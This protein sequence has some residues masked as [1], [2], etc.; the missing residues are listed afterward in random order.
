MVVI[1]GDVRGV[2]LGNKQG[3]WEDPIDFISSGKVPT[4]VLGLK[5][6]PID[7]WVFLFSRILCHHKMEL[8]LTPTKRLSIP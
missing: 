4:D 6:S 2:F 1:F 8:E 5:Y 3:P 7:K